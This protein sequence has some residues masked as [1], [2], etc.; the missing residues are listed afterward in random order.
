MQTHISIYIYTYTYIHIS[1]YITVDRR[2]KKI[3][4]KM[5]KK[6]SRTS[7]FEFLDPTTK[8]CKNFKNLDKFFLGAENSSGIYVYVC[9]YLYV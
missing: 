5:L 1:I 6:G 3:S 2:G 4:Q 9:I 8:K 7:T